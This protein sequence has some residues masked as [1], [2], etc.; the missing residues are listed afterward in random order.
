MIG[1]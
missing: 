1:T